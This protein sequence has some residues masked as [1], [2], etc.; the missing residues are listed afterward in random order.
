MGKEGRDVEPTEQPFLSRSFHRKG[1]K[2]GKV[3]EDKYGLK[4]GLFIF[5][6]FSLVRET[7]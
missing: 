1:Q 2:E 6:F 7:Y 5:S 4:E 3:A